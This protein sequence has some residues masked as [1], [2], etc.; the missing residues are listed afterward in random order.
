MLCR[1]C[2]RLCQC[3]LPWTVAH[4]PFEVHQPIVEVTTDIPKEYSGFVGDLLILDSTKACCVCNL[5]ILMMRHCRSVLQVEMH[6]LSMT[7]LIVARLFCGSLLRHTEMEL[8]QF[9]ASPPNLKAVTHSK[10]L[11]PLQPTRLWPMLNKIHI[12]YLAHQMLL[13]RQ[14]TTNITSTLW[15]RFAFH[16][17]QARRSW[18][19]SVW[20]LV[21]SRMGVHFGAWC[22]FSTCS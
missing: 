19:V 1:Y 11:K 20:V 18:S 22:N 15:C 21:S 3:D 10:L 12:C 17:V 14:A 2:I 13:V 8:V 6:F 4:L 16:S 9:T 7:L 5:W